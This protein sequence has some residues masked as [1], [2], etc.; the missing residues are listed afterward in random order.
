MRL[1]AVKRGKSFFTFNISTCCKNN[2][3]VRTFH[4]CVKKLAL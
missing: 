4:D 2:N 1:Q 3:R